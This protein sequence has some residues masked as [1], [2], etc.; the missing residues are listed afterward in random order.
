MRRLGTAP[1]IILYPIRRGYLHLA[2]LQSRQ[3]TELL[4][5]LT[6]IRGF[7]P[8]LM[9]QRNGLRWTSQDRQL[10]KK[11]MLSLAR[12][13]P[14]AAALLLPGGM[15][16]LPLLAWWLDRRRLKRSAGSIP[17]DTDTRRT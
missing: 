11:Q 14:Y 9:K 5:E 17:A 16:A 1:A 6:E 15:L 4:A 8:L 3:R 13:S 10:I 12:L 7:M 2:A